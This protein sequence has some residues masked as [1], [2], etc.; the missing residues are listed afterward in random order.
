AQALSEA[1]ICSFDKLFFLELLKKSPDLT[2]NLLL[3]FANEL[4]HVESTLRDLTVF[5]VREKVAKAL[6]SLIDSFGLSKSN[7]INHISD[8]TRQNI[9]EIV[10]LNSNQISKVFAEFKEDKILETKGKNIKILN[11]KKLEQIIQL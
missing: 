3:F 2:F 11:I 10:G 4:N 8:L 9:A 5:N 7:N 6:L 1:I